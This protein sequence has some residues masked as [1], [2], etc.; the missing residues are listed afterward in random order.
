MDVGAP[1]TIGMAPRVIGQFVREERLLTLEEAVRRMTSLPMSVVGIGDR[2]QV[3]PGMWADIT[4]FNPDTVIDRAT[5]ENPHQYAVG[6]RHVFVNGV[7]VLK[8]GE[9]TGAKPGMVVR[10]PGYTG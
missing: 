7:Q 3:K 10:G 8:D 2:G 4:V 6:M 5:Y 1:S 9:H